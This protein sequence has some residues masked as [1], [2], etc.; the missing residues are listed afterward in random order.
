M[1][2]MSLSKKKIK[3]Q[4]KQYSAFQTASFIQRDSTD[5]ETNL[6]HPGTFNI[7]EA[8]IDTDANQK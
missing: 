4:S 5:E 6:A 7:T 3:N 8:K 2:K 1:K